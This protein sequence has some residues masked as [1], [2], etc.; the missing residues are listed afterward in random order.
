MF[1]RSELRRITE[2]QDTTNHIPAGV[3]PAFGMWFLCFMIF[4]NIRFRFN[5]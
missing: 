1:P 3:K 5:K 4:Y 2:K